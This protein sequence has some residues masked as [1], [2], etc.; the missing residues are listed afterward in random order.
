[1]KFLRLEI[2]NIASIE[3]AVIDFAASPLGDSTIFLICG[4]TGSGKSTILDA[5]TLAL[6]NRAPRIEGMGRRRNIGFDDDND[7]GDSDGISR[8]SDTRQLVRRGAAAASV[9]LDFIGNNGQPYRSTWDVRRKKRL[10]TLDKVAHSLTDLTTNHTLRLRDEV[11]AAIE[12][13]EIVGLDYPRFC[14]TTLLAQGEFSRFLS[15]DNA[16]KAQI[17]EKLTGID[18]YAA[19]GNAIYEKYKAINEQYNIAAAA[20]KDSERISPDDIAELE[21]AVKILENECVTLTKKLDITKSELDLT[22][23]RKALADRVATSKQ[24]VEIITA[25][26]SSQA[27]S[28]ACR[29]VDEAEALEAPCRKLA[30][31][32]RLDKAL[33]DAD[34]AT[35]S[36]AKEY[37]DCIAVYNTVKTARDT[38]AVRAS[39][40]KLELD[41]LE[42]SR[43]K[44]DNADLF[45][46]MLGDI[47]NNISTIDSHRREIESQKAVIAAN[48]KREHEIT[49]VIAELDNT[50]E[51]LRLSIAEKEQHMA[52]FDS[53]NVTSA[54]LENER[55]RSALASLSDAQSRFTTLSAR[56][57]ACSIESVRLKSTQIWLSARL[58]DAGTKQGTA[59]TAL[60]SLRTALDKARLDAAADIEAV[61]ARLNPGDSCPVCGAIVSVLPQQAEL[62]AKSKAF[63]ALENDAEEALEKATAT[64]NRYRRLI[65]ICKIRAEE[66]AATA[67]ALHSEMTDNEVIIKNLT[68]QLGISDSQN[69]ETSIK[70][71]GD[72]LDAEQKKLNETAA[73]LKKLRADTDAARSALT[74]SERERNTSVLKRQNV[75]ADSDKKRAAIERLQTD[76][77]KISDENSAI[78]ARLSTHGINVADNTDGIRQ[79]QDDLERLA[80]RH[81]ALSDRLAELK[82]RI[83][84]ADTLISRADTPIARIRALYP[85]IDDTPAMP[86]AP[87]FEVNELPEK[88]S[89]LLEKLSDNTGHRRRLSSEQSQLR[90]EL[91]RFLGDNIDFDI[92]TLRHYLKDN[93][94][95]E[96]AKA[97]LLIDSL[98]KRLTESRAIVKDASA[99]LDKFDRDNRLPEAD[100][101]TLAETVAAL[102]AQIASARTT[103]GQRRAALDNARNLYER[104]RLSLERL[105][106]LERT[107]AKW[108]TLNRLFGG[109]GGSRMSQIAQSHILSLL[110]DNANYYLGLF[111]PRYRMF[112]S[113]GNLQVNI[114]DRDRG[115]E[116]RPFNTLSG[117]ESFMVSLALALG[118]SSV[119]S[120]NTTP[121]IIFI[122]EGFGSLS[123]DCLEQV[124]STLATLRLNEGRRVGI[125][126][127][128]DSLR[129]RISTTIEVR[130][131]D[132]LSSSICVRRR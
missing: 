90:L 126:S 44:I 36:M 85:Q 3:H 75:I 5:I 78:T 12:S 46:K 31:I 127:H 9:T 55:H 89:A 63:E 47:A 104:Q 120:V 94:V 93:T 95:A 91:D 131:S 122:D 113:P 4:E 101:S 54:L 58:S 45:I 115:N 132:N 13:P 61:R 16:T 106:E 87:V 130:T 79:Q 56:Q 124:T 88:L 22:L 1:M 71:L 26:I 23:Q 125:I 43:S 76:I 64:V 82:S 25:E 19:V 21:K 129:D 117:G 41:S 98:N 40:T 121:D 97:R 86:A 7:A 118:L 107:A 92:D 11:S 39:D 49:A 110:L 70:K 37:S 53:D 112:S 17:L 74:D 128:V 114:C 84:S 103:S 123:A 8:L 10:G 59:Q 14:R 105:V 18:R 50:A 34:E 96:V 99:L 48:D 42:P 73:S 102:E 51:K 80:K 27:T 109:D 111:T 6:Y 52:A 81:K 69:L 66:T 29:L 24:A 108:T 2:N 62:I 38:V 32:D 15:A 119:Q 116:T 28:E 33:K 65:D 72:S 67:S 100:S 60:R 68:T 57:N 30:E 35:E 83:D 77:A 20:F